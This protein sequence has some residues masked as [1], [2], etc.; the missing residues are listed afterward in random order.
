[1]SNQLLPNSVQFVFINDVIKSDQDPCIVSE[2]FVP[3]W[4]DVFFVVRLISAVS[5][6]LLRQ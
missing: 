4:C 2:W 5:A 1:M 6:L 3:V